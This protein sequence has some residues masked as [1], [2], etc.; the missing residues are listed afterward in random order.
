MLLSDRYRAVSCDRSRSPHRFRREMPYRKREYGQMRARRK[1]EQ[2]LIDPTKSHH[3]E[4][5]NYDNLENLYANLSN[6]S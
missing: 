6:P 3:Y 4:Q 1:R 5:R 2:S